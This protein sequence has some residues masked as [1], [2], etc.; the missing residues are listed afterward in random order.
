MTAADRLDALIV[1]DEVL[2]AE[3][4]ACLLRGAGLRDIGPALRGGDHAG[5]G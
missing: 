1:E 3:E 2:L 4:F 5:A